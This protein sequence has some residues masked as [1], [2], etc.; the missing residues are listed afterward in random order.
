M[1]TILYEPNQRAKM[2]WLKT[3]ET[4]FL[5]ILQSRELI[6]QLFRRDFFMAYKKSFIGFSWIFITPI[7]GIVSWVF[8]NATGILQPGD[9]GI[10]Y[11]AYVLLSSSIYGLWG[12]FQAAAS[13][14]LTAGNG[15][16]NQVSYPHDVLLIK[17][18]MLQIAN[19]LI[20][21]VINIIVLICF[22]VVPSWMI[23]L[24]PI[25]VLPLFFLGSAIGL[26]IC[27]VSVVAQDISKLAN[28][29]LGLIM[30]IT[31][32]IY[33]PKVASPLLQKIIVYNPLTYLLGGCRDAILYGHIT[34]LKQ[35][36]FFS[37]CTFV[38][39][40]IAWRVFYVTEQKVIEKM[41]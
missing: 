17:E 3:W 5:N 31:P 12:S 23:I 30:F 9:V 34:H 40:L 2:G 11:P 21:F 8:Y 29:A 41:L 38:F 18:T 4:M 6:W 33:S 32:V 19:F 10:P 28:Y 37:V 16:I 25:L 13:N 27:I 1:P 7:M 39:F 26:I 20:S 14:T 36:L 35:Y 22:G 24:F 15:F